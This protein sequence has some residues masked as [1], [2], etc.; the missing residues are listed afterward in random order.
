[1]VLEL[2]EIETYR[3]LLSEQIIG[4]LITQVLIQDEKLINLESAVFQQELMGQTVLFIERRGKYLL[5][6]LD[7]GRRV[8]VHLGAAG[9]LH[10]EADH[11]DG[12]ASS[13]QLSIQFGMGVLHISGI[14]Q[15]FIHSLSVKEADDLMKELGPELFDRRM[16]LAKFKALFGKKRGMLKSALVQQQFVAGLGNAY[17]DEIAFAAELMPTVKLQELSEA[18]TERLYHSIQAVIGSAIEFGGAGEHK[19]TAQ[20]ALTGGYKQHM[21]VFERE[22]QPCSRCGGKIHKAEIGS[23]KTYYCADCQQQQ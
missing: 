12:L 23:R 10:F 14:R 4:K 2:P 16:T 3:R 15:G 17:A 8:L 19:F 21:Q 6:H 1:M 9:S 18:S 22:G 13:D 5:W 20:D 11:P 7:N